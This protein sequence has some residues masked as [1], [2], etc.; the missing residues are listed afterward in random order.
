MLTRL[1]DLCLRYRP[2][3]LLATAVLALVG[4]LSLRAA[5]V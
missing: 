5:T 2:A 4:L 3:V 1:I